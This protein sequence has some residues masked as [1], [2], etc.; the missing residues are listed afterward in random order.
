MK[1]D[2][3]IMEKIFILS[4]QRTP[5]GAFG[6]SL[7]NISATDLAVQASLA[8]L[9]SANF[10]AKY[11]D[12]I[13]FGSV[14][15]SAHDAIYL[16]RHVGLKVDAPQDTPALGINR[17]CGTGFEVIASAARLIQTGEA[18]SVLAGGVEQMSQIPYVVKGARWGQRMGHGDV[19][20]VLVSALTDSFTGLSM[21][22][23]AENL[24]EQYD[25][26]REQVDQYAYESQQRCASAMKENIFDLEQTDVTVKTRRGTV[27][28]NKDEHA[29]PETTLEKLKSLKPIF[30]KNGVVTAGNASGIVDGAASTLVVSEKEV[31]KKSFKPLVRIVGW[32][33]VGCDP[34]IMGIG[35]V[36]A[37]KD[38]L[39]KTGL[40]LKQMDLIEVNEAFAAQYL[41]VEKEL[42]LPRER[43]NVNGGAIAIGHPL[44]ATGTRIMN[45]LVHQL[46][47]KKLKYGLGSACIGG[48]QGIAMIVERWA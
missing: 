43:T 36:Q 16:P 47:H 6:G 44:A 35:P 8:T 21:A 22:M 10:E 27:L 13:V 24:A 11:L 39:K 37:I 46:H 9:K 17:L 15:Q 7:K 2:C 31:R 28:F 29:K 32:S 33:S 1:G 38:V 23:T 25:L 30:K 3:K 4:G 5:F 42:N 48:G 14:I 20:D 34:K 19:E 41:A 12:H 45:H 40:N 26:S 18:Q